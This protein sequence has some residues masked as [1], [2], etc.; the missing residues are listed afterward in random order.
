VYSISGPATLYS[1]FNNIKAS[2]SVKP[3]ISGKE[4]STKNGKHKLT[5]NKGKWSGYPIP[6]ITMQWYVCT[7]QVKSVTQTIPKTCK[8]ISKATK[9]TLAV[10]STYKGK[11][12]A[13]AVSGKGTGTSATR[14]LSK[15]TGKVK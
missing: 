9:S 11:Y 3:K 10:T 8:L 7:K 15:S 14:W 13:V 4:I 1:K 12:I 2:A 5:A 6:N